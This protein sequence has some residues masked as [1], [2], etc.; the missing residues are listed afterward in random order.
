MRLA[1]EKAMFQGMEMHFELI[2]CLLNSPKCVLRNA[3]KAVFQLF[4]NLTFDL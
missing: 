1:F 3:Q 4:R 2:F